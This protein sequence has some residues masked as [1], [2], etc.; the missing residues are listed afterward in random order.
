MMIQKV[1][2]IDF[3]FSVLNMV[4]KLHFS[5]NCTLIARGKGIGKQT[6]QFIK[7]QAKLF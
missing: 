6:I 5:T 2:Y 3:L 7:E 4:E 1:G